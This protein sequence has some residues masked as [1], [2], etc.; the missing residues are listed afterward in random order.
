MSSKNSSDATN[1]G[2][3]TKRP[4][5]SIEDGFPYESA[6]VIDDVTW[7]R[8]L[9]LTLSSRIT[10]LTSYGSAVSSVQAGQVAKISAHNIGNHLVHPYSGGATVQVHNYQVEEAFVKFLAHWIYHRDAKE[11]IDASMIRQNETQP[12]EVDEEWLVFLLKAMNFFANR[13]EFTCDITDSLVDT[14]LSFTS[15]KS[16]LVHLDQIFTICKQ[17][18]K[19]SILARIFANLFLHHKKQ[20]VKQ[21]PN[22]AFERITQTHV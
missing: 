8:Q 7:C 14:V 4:K 13:A 19:T 16:A 10:I 15:T 6:T 17:H 18:C 9:N 11:A 5:P 12:G 1:D 2:P 21:T 20:F 3:A 22:D